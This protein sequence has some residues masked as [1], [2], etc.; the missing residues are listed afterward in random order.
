MGRTRS[1]YSFSFGG[2]VLGSEASPEDAE[3]VEL[4]DLE[5][6]EDP[7]DLEESEDPEDLEESEA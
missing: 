2:T 4:E 1:K 6:S 5:E 3:E 7:E